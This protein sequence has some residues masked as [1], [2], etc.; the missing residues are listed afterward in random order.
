VKPAPS[1]PRTRRGSNRFF[2]VRREKAEGRRKAKAEV[3]RKANQ[4]Q[5]RGKDEFALPPSSF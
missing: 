4:K 3:R 2:E 5:E 1:G